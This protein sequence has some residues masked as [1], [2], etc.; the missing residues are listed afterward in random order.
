M[1]ANNDH[2]V[3][4]Y[5]NNYISD[6]EPASYYY[7]KY[8]YITRIDFHY[9]YGSDIRR[10]YY[11]DLDITRTYG[12][13]CLDSSNDNHSSR[14]DLYDLYYSD[15]YCYHHYAGRHNDLHGTGS[16]CE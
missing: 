15:N 1:H 10:Y 16:H 2:T 11:G 9:L 7:N 8:L 14:S 6:G 5:S 13:R 4:H 3:L 12:N